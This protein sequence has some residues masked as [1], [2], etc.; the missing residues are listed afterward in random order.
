LILLVIILG[1]TGDNKQGDGEDV[2]IEDDGKLFC[3]ER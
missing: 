3:G 1:E 2:N